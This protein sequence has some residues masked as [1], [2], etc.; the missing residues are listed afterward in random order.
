MFVKITKLKKAVA[1][2]KR[3]VPF[4]DSW[5]N[6]IPGSYTAEM[7]QCLLKEASLPPDAASCSERS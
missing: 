4:S 7:H 2:D 5:L 3:M 1:F 6:G